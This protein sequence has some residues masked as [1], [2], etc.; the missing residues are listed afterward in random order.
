MRSRPSPG[1]TQ[2]QTES[3]IA[4]ARS[5]EA[6]TRVQTRVARYGMR[7]RAPHQAVTGAHEGAG[8]CTMA[9]GMAAAAQTTTRNAMSNSQSVLKSRLAAVSLASWVKRASIPS[10]VVGPASGTTRR[11]AATPMRESW[12]KW[13]SMIGVTGSWAA[14]LTA[15]A[16]AS[17]CGQPRSFKNPVNG[18]A[19]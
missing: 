14:R 6:A 15:T 3:A 19:R 5:T 1:L 12:L 13:A 11:L 18:A 8:R 2:G 9:P 4:T 16:A 17:Q 10:V 7:S